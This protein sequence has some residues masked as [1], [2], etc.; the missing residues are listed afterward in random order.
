M[1]V[2]LGRVRD[3]RG[4]KVLKVDAIGRDAQTTNDNN[5]IHDMSIL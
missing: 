1:A 3:E 5:N 2:V 4:V